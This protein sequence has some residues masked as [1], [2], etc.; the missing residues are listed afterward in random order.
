MSIVLERTSSNLVS[1][2]RRRNKPIN[3]TPHS[4]PRHFGNGL[5]NFSHFKHSTFGFDKRVAAPSSWSRKIV[6]VLIALLDRFA[7]LWSY[8]KHSR[9]VRHMKLQRQLDTQTFGGFQISGLPTHPARFLLLTV[10]IVTHFE[11]FFRT[12]IALLLFKLAA[13]PLL[14]KQPSSG[15]RSPS[16][17]ATL[18]IQRRVWFFGVSKSNRC[19]V[20]TILIC[21]SMF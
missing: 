7:A 5:G 1:T 12:P 10:A 11:L 4:R 19:Y 20:L 14:V 3:H 8:K 16:T 2:R 13:A 21:G 9:C 15:K 6:E 17:K 18:T